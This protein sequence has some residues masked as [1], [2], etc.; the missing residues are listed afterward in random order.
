MESIYR[1]RRK[2]HSRGWRAIKRKSSQ[3][4]K[5]RAALDSILTEERVHIYEQQGYIRSSHPTTLVGNEVKWYAFRSMSADVLDNAQ[6]AVQNDDTPNVFLRVFFQSAKGHIE[7]RNNGASGARLDC[8][9]C[10]PRFDFPAVTNLET[11]IGANPTFLLDGFSAVAPLL[12]EDKDT[13]SQSGQQI[14]ASPYDS[15]TWTRFFKIKYFQGYDLR[16]GDTCK[17]QTDLTRPF[18]FSKAK[19]GCIVRTGDPLAPNFDTAIATVWNH[20]RAWGPIYLVRVQGTIMH[21]EADLAGAFAKGGIYTDFHIDWFQRNKFTFK[22]PYTQS[23][24][25]QSRFSAALATVAA[26]SNANQYHQVAVA[27]QAT[28]GD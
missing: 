22:A 19:Y 12:E 5:I 25:R 9:R 4:S 14:G 27:E 21:D 23:L 2:S 10:T 16:V 11:I 7:L 3:G 13:T 24:R 18:Q 28:T 20:L 8:W 17:L 1:K 26:A 6:K 15:V